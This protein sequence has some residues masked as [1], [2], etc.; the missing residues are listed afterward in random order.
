M[1]ELGYTSVDRIL[2]KLSRDLGMDDISEADVIEWTGEAL[3]A[4]DAVTM[5]EEAVYFAEVKNHQVQLP[6]FL[7][8]IIQIARNNEF[9]EEECT[10]HAIV[11]QMSCDLPDN[12]YEDCPTCDDIRYVPVDHLNVPLFETDRE[13]FR[14]NI[15]VLAEYIDWVECDYYTR[16]WTP[17]RLK[18]HT[19]FNSLVCEE[20]GQEDLYQNSED[21][22]TIIGNKI[23][24]FSFKTGFVAIA[25]TRQMLDENGYPMI[26]DHYSYVTAVTKYITMKMME[27]EWYSGRQGFGD[28]VK[29]SEQ[30]WQWYCKQAGNRAIMPEGLDQFQNML[31]Q[32]QYLLPRIH[33]YNQFFKDM[34][35]RE[36]RAYND[37]DGRNQHNYRFN[38]DERRQY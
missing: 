22:Y 27:R 35:R 2:S 38:R 8:S 5:L 14:P 11:E 26:P 36:N 25:Y 33:R 13:K 19:F 30:D 37:P 6:M 31:D 20:I 21:E 17:V 29:K 32:R 7:D 24:R 16:K 15:N 23:V 1:K 3:E 4:I 18:N 9:T 12:P 10:P 34:G 28:K